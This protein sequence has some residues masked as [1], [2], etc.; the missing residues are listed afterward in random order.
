MNMTS[1][2]VLAD[3]DEMKEYAEESEPFVGCLQYVLIVLVLLLAI[4]ATARVPDYSVRI[5]ECG[6]DFAG[7]LGCW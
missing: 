2:D 6:T 4:R 3:L 1:D 7:P 5:S